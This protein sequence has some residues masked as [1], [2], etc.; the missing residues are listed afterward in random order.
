MV[1]NV[2]VEGEMDPGEP[3]G[4]LVP[5]RGL[6]RD[7]VEDCDERFFRVRDVAHEADDSKVPEPADKREVARSSRATVPTA[8][9][10]FLPQHSDL[11]QG[12]VMLQ[13][14]LVCVL[15]T[16]TSLVTCPGSKWWYLGPNAGHLKRKNSVERGFGCTWAS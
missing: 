9:D 8:V 4:L 5:P 15:D 13:R 16:P 2:V 7:A 6:R 10:H 12:I 14:A 1:S 11:P 3:R